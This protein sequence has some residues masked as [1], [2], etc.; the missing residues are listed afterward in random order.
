MWRRWRL[1]LESI[2]RAFASPPGDEETFPLDAVDAI[3]V[4]RHAKF[5]TALPFPLLSWKDEKCVECSLRELRDYVEQLANGALDWYLEK[6]TSKKRFAVCLHWWTYIFGVLA[7]LIP[8]L[9]LNLGK[10]LDPFVKQYLGIESNLSSIAAETALLLA[11]IAGGATLIDR[12]AGFT[13]DWMRY[14]TT[15]ARINRALIEFQFAWNKID[16]ASPYPPPSGTPQPSIKRGKRDIDPV[17]Q[18]IELAKEFCSKIFEFM[19]QETSIWADEMKER[20]AQAARQ[21]QP[22]RP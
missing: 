6:K 13:A 16:Q 20:V 11:G 7:A 14:I 9:M 4:T 12:A 22:Q 17:T 2:R 19:D 15:A 8:L 1:F 10:F 21:L 3:R 18:R 5:C